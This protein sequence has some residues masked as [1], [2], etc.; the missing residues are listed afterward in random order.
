MKYTRE[1]LLEM[2]QVLTEAVNQFEI[3]SSREILAQLDA[4]R[5]DE[6]LPEEKKNSAGQLY[7]LLHQSNDLLYGFAKRYHSVQNDIDKLLQIHDSGNLDERAD[8]ISNLEDRLDSDIPSL[9]TSAANVKRAADRYFLHGEGSYELTPAYKDPSWPLYGAAQTL[10]DAEQ[11]L[12]SLTNVVSPAAYQETDRQ[13]EQEMTCLAAMSCDGTDLT[14][15]EQLQEDAERQAYNAKERIRKLEDEKGTWEKNYTDATT[16]LNQVTVE[17]NQGN[18]R[19]KSLSTE[20]ERQEKALAD[21]E[22]SEKDYGNLVTEVQKQ[23]ERINNVDEEIQKLEQ[24]RKTYTADVNRY[25]VAIDDLKIWIGKDPKEQAR[26]RSYISASESEQTW[27]R[28]KR[29][30]ED[31]KKEVAGDPVLQTLLF[32]EPAA[33]YRKTG[34][35][36]NYVK[37]LDAQLSDPNNPKAAKVRRC[38]EIIDKMM[39]LAPDKEKLADILTK[40]SNDEKDFF[41]KMDTDLNDQITAAGLEV[42][43]HSPAQELQD[44]NTTMDNLLTSLNQTEEELERA[45][46]KLSRLLERRQESEVRLQAM[47]STLTS[48]QDQLKTEKK[49]K[50]KKKDRNALEAIQ[51]QINSVMQQKQDLLE[52]RRKFD[53]DQGKLQKDV[54]LKEE[55]CTNAR[56]SI[57]RYREAI[58]NKTFSPDMIDSVIRD[59]LDGLEK[60]G[61]IEENLKFCRRR[62]ERYAEEIADPE[63]RLKE[64]GAHFVKNYSEAY[65][66][67]HENEGNFSKE[68]KA[69]TAALDQQLI[70]KPEDLDKLLKRLKEP[71]A[72][73]LKSN[74]EALDSLKRKAVDLEG[75]R[76]EAESKVKQYAPQKYRAQLSTAQLDLEEGQRKA[77]RYKNLRSHLNKARKLHN[78]KV[79]YLTQTKSAY[80]KEK[81][82]I[83]KGINEFKENFDKNKK[84]GHNNTPEYEAIK[85]VLNR[86]TEASMKDMS[87]E[88]LKQNLADLKSATDQYRRKKEKQ[89]FHWNPSPQRK[90]RLEQSDHIGRFADKHRQLADTL[91]KNMKQFQDVKMPKAGEIGNEQAFA[92]FAQE[93]KEHYDQKIKPFSDMVNE[94]KQSYEAKFFDDNHLTENEQKERRKQLV[95]NALVNSEVEK[96]LWDFDPSQKPLG[97]YV[98]ELTDFKTKT[99][100]RF[101]QKEGAFINK[102]AETV[103]NEKNQ[104]MTGKDI[105]QKWQRKN[106]PKYRDFKDY[107][108]NIKDLNKPGKEHGNQEREMNPHVPGLV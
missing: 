27:Q 49:D 66:L 19:I 50:K 84:A 102:T 4:Q 38:K 89:L 104:K 21:L 88:A 63:R 30:S 44:L 33:R 91:E 51:Q 28:I 57:D 65:S 36:T 79:A 15:L 40:R 56:E 14:Q 70:G 37:D 60:L 78:Q 55:V 62:K 82:A 69:L 90:Y 41:D 72:D 29:L 94:V 58:A 52:E 34:T 67:I 9:S 8:E 83:L 31:L 100:N 23:R 47:D 1:T 95:M 105:A 97:I 98:V 20:I 61:P 71:I 77:T 85:T 17:L 81:A 73:S 6:N 107:N 86:F 74:R 48:L 11:R 42:A 45:R 39:A 54:A 35:A 7:D 59:K 13:W 80:D 64:A 53:N 87:P 10:Y 25:P 22:A 92:G 96:K 46:K 2:K 32:S 76:L 99:E 24:E 43:K 5:K 3:L 103:I 16:R 106:E 75:D 26:L 68:Q 18:N 93:Y 101:A 12:N 108:Q